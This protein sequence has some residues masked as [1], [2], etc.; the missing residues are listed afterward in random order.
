MQ[1]SWRLPSC[2]SFHSVY[3]SH[4]RF[5][6]LSPPI[7]S[8]RKFPLS[9]SSKRRQTFCSKRRDFVLMF[10][11]FIVLLWLNG[12]EGGKDWHYMIIAWKDDVSRSPVS[13]ISQKS[14]WHSIPHG[15]IIPLMQQ[16][17][18]F[19]GFYF[20]PSF[21]AS[22][23]KVCEHFLH[24]HVSFY[25]KIT[26]NALSKQK[27]KQKYKSKNS[28]RQESK[29]NKFHGKER[30]ARKQSL[31]LF[32]FVYLFFFV[33]LLLLGFLV[34]H[35][36]SI[37]FFVCFPTSEL[38]EFQLIICPEIDDTTVYLQVDN[39]LHCISS[40]IEATAKESDMHATQVIWFVFVSSI[41][42]CHSTRMQ[43][44]LLNNSPSRFI[45]ASK[46]LLSLQ[47]RH[48]FLCVLSIGHLP[49]MSAWALQV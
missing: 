9:S 20:M 13:V 19:P 43:T 38:L 14:F 21:S 40:P 32:S 37:C 18:A 11:L 47:A 36:S 10:V 39:S 8:V 15:H 16:L 31:N 42:S 48:W 17:E 33:F 25:K 41:L 4:E 7:L 49:F 44:I 29:K 5:S 27:Q 23:L 6:F 24:F 28:K 35:Q 2:L 45:C 46:H 1:S 34:L 3:V 26:C 22:S 30:Q 12:K